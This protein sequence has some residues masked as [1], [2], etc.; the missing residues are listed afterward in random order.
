MGCGAALVFGV[1]ILVMSFLSAT[2]PKAAADTTTSMTPVASAS[3]EKSEYYLPYPGILPDSPLFKLKAVRDRIRVLVS[4]DKLKRA[5]VELLLADKRINAAQA[6]FDGG[7]E[8]LAV[9]TATK[10]EKYLW[11]S[12]EDTMTLARSGKDVKSMLLILSKA[13]VKHLEM[14]ESM[15]LK[16]SAANQEVLQKS[17]DS[18]QT[19]VEQVKQAVIDN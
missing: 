13:G 15:R 7:K 18:T 3:A 11:Q 9:S 5:E 6:L 19:M 8:D 10:A 2:H 1:A 4:F 17:E 16:S 14:L 12:A